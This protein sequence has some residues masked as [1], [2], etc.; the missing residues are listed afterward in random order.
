MT[1]HTSGPDLSGH[2]GVQRVLAALRA[3]GVEPAVTVLPDATRTAQLAADALGITPAQI[4]NSLIF[5]ATSADGSVGPLLVLASGGHRVDT[6]RVRAALGYTK[7]GR[8]DA[9]F[10]RAWTGFA[11]GGVAPVGHLHDGVPYAVPTVVD[12]ALAAFDVVWAAAGHAHTVFP[13]SFAELVRI[14]GGRPLT[15][16]D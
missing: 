9:D 4:A 15:V 11:I 13:T 6:E 8:A 5:S 1:N 14:T 2:S 12:E 7:V 16:G 10:V 3:A